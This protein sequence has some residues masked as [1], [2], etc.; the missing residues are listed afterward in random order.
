MLCHSRRC[1]S[2]SW[3]SSRFK[4]CFSSFNLAAQ[5]GAGADRPNA[6]A[7]GSAQRCCAGSTAWAL[8]HE[9]IHLPFERVGFGLRIC[10]VCGRGAVC[11]C[12][13]L[14]S[15]TRRV[16][17]VLSNRAASRINI[18]FRTHMDWCRR[19]CGSLLCLGRRCLCTCEDIAGCP[20][21]AFRRDS[22]PGERHWW[23]SI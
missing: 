8:A 23:R 16:L 14:C 9:E 11:R 6:S 12:A 2:L 22:Y 10:A 1:H 15:R 13:F 7:F 21:A 17:L 20:C 19:V 18:G 5:Q 4:V 3:Q